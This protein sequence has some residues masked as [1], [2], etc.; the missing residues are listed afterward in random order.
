MSR[1]KI[2]ISLAISEIEHLPVNVLTIC[3]VCFQLGL[4]S[5]LLCIRALCVL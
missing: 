2:C 3:F 5:F 4:F 1:L